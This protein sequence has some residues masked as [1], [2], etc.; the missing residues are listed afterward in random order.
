MELDMQW[1]KDGVWFI[2]LIGS[3]VGLYWKLRTTRPTYE[4]VEKM[5]SDKSYSKEA[6]IRLEERHT[7]ALNNMKILKD[8]LNEIADDVKTLLQKK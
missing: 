5:I 3:V 6:G 7:A 1:V 2:M 4:K 8:K